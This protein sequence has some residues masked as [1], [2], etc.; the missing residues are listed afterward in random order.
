M[1]VPR[2]HSAT[3]L[4]PQHF[5]ADPYRSRCRVRVLVSRAAGLASPGLVPGSM[6]VHVWGFLLYWVRNWTVPF[7]LLQPFL[8]PLETRAHVA[9][10][11]VLSFPRVRWNFLGL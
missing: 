11:S 1:C 2:K 4:Q 10:I 9:F 3:E 5:R 7:C 6:C 8:N